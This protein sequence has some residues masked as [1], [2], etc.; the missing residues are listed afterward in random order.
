MFYILNLTG[1]PWSIGG[2]AYPK[3]LEFKRI[4]FSLRQKI[5]DIP[6]S[7]VPSHS[8]NND[9]SG[10]ANALRKRKT[11]LRLLS[12]AN[13]YGL[14]YSLSNEMTKR[15]PLL[16]NEFLLATFLD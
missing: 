12:S 4:Y 15:L 9:L 16:I 11:F 7:F 1:N 10:L 6:T 8:I 2:W 13:S 14:F 5:S 3:K